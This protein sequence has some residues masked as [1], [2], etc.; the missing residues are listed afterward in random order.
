MMKCIFLSLFKIFIDS[1]LIRRKYEKNKNK[2]QIVEIKSRDK[3]TNCQ[4]Y[5]S[6]TFFL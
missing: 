6:K 1:F 4:V 2:I 3:N 5:S